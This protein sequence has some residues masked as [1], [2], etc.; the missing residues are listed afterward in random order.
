MSELI[1]D[2]GTVMIDTSA[3]QNVV[4]TR[5]TG[6]RFDSVDGNPRVCQAN[7]THSLLVTRNHKVF[8]AEKP[9]PKLENVEHLKAALVKAGVL[10]GK[11]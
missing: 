1:L 8:N 7:E 5:I 3:I 4:P 10:P 11:A 2:K 9:L 6:W